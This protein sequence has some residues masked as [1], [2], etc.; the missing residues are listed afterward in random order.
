[1]YVYKCYSTYVHLSDWELECFPYQQSAIFS[2]LAKSN[3]IKTIS[4]HASG[5][6]NKVE[7]DSKDAT[8]IDFTKLFTWEIKEVLSIA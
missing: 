5:L 4:V 3:L 6:S 8:K 1:M 2:M 7:K